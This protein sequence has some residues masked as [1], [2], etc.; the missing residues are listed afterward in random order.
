MRIVHVPFCFRPDPV[1]GTE[2]YVEA[3]AHEQLA[4][5][6]HV[7][8]AAPGPKNAA[9]VLDGL[10]VRRFATAPHVGLTTLY[11]AGDS[12]ASGE[13]ARVLDDEK[14]DIVHLHALTSAVSIRLVDEARRHG[15]GVVF[16][17]HTPTV[18]C[19]RGTLLWRGREVCDGALRVQRC[20]Q[21]ALEGLGAG[22]LGS[23]V[24]SKV[25]SAVGRF[26]DELGLGDSS[27]LTGVRFSHLLE[28]QHAA[29]RALMSRVQRVVVLCGWTRDVLVRN[30]VADEKIVISRHGLPGWLGEPTTKRAEGPRAGRLRVAFLG[31]LHPTKGP[32]VLIQAIK[33]LTGASI[34]LHVFGIEQRG[35]AE[36]ADSLHR[37]AAGDR[38]IVFHQ[39]I[40]ATRVVNVL[41]EFDV[42]AV[43]SQW[44][45]TG[46][47]VVLEAFAAQT[48]VVGSRLGGIAELVQDGIDGIL[49]RHDSIEEWARTLIM[50]AQNPATVRRLRDGVRPPQRMSAV[51]DEMQT[52]YLDCAAGSR[53]IAV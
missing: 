32:D 9:Y 40:P 16:T 36:Y 51:S 27:F 49:V 14:P 29:W 28:T 19:Q 6:M 2:V 12:V 34:E 45:E 44:L 10:E 5:G 47:L 20:A 37:L 24:L 31:R 18:S 23:A 15:A 43:P 50:L 13:F 8:V 22:R 30:G 7:V 46:P 11:G 4:R 26:C 17:Y 38:R 3:L 35:D 1:G 39:E 53:A 21:C 48:P 41:M 42:L 25:P 33:R 52:V